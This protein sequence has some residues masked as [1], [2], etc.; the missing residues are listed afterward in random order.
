MAN[1]I[2]EDAST[3]ICKHM[4]HDHSVSIFAMVSRS[5][6]DMSRISHCRMTK[7]TSEGCSIA[8]V[9]CNGNVCEQRNTFIE[10]SPPIT[11]VKEVR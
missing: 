4:N 7:L 1:E 9:Y 11:S 8:F 6:S 2:T 5:A 10:F 3:R